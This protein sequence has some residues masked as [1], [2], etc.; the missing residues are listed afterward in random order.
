[1]ALLAEGAERGEMVI[2]DR[3][4]Y[5]RVL[6]ERVDRTIP[7][8]AWR[9]A[10]RDIVEF[11]RVL[12]D[13]GAV[14]LKF[15]LHISKKEQRE[16]FR[17]IKADPLEAWR[18][19]D[20]DW[21]RQKKYDEYRPRSRRCSN[22]RIRIRAVDHRRSHFE[23]VRAQAHLRDHRGGPR[24]APGRQR[25][26]TLRRSPAVAAKDASCGKPWIRSRRAALMLETLDLTRTLTREAYVREVTRRQ[27]QLREWATRSTCK[28]VR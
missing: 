3:S 21:A 27:I 16:R 1:V 14:I 11:E 15:F 17:A 6:D 23:M 2:F 4:W 25:A 10:Y 9:Q 13:D 28:N 5:F 24:K 26:A 8:K 18:V 12:A 20:A 22:D 7:E 19:S